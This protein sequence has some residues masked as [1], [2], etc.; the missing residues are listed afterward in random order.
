MVKPAKW[1]DL[2]ALV[3]S[4]LV[5]GGAAYWTLHTGIFSAAALSTDSKIAW[6][7]TRSAGISA[8]FLLLAS[9]VWGLFISGQYVKN[10]SP[11]ALSLTMHSTISWLA[12]ILGFTHA[13]LLL[14]DT[15]FHYTVSDI[16]I[17]FTGPYRPLMVGF[18]T[19]S[20]WL[21]LVVALSFQIKRRIGHRAWKWI[22]MMSYG[23]FAMVTLH[24][25]TA[26]TD[27]ELLGLRLLVG[28][29]VLVVVLLLGIRM[30]K[31][32]GRVA[33]PAARP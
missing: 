17:P 12:L 14:G 4:L 19:L 28:G 9:M 15:Y 7:L 33:K 22:H 30:G 3:F 20:I 23:A 16:L 8:Y 13:F 6:H 27:S 2:L 31:D 25:L 1:M 32:Q 11:G 5:I 10:W 24:G 26:G 21:L 29:S 18:G